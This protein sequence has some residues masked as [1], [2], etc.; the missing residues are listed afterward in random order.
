MFNK[1]S[2]SET[3]CPICGKPVYNN[4][5]WERAD[6]VTSRRVH[7]E[8]TRNILFAAKKKLDK[9]IKKCKGKYNTFEI[10]E[11]NHWSVNKAYLDGEI[12]FVCSRGQFA[13]VDKRGVSII[14]YYEEY[15]LPYKLP[16]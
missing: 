10:L 2:Y 11:I 12:D 14:P 16:I 3:P 9:E 15:N 8:C 6:S 5:D 4:D 7:T 13:F 1:L